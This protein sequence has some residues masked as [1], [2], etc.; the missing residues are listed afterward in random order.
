MQVVSLY[1]DT[2]DREL[3]R[4][5]GEVILCQIR[6]TQFEFRAPVAAD[7]YIQ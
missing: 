2:I 5:C 6:K 3:D 7:A 1:T 4:C